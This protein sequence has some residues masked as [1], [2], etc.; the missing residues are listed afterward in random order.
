[1]YDQIHRLDRPVNILVQKTTKCHALQ[2][3]I[4]FGIDLYNGRDT[5][6]VV[7]F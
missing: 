4:A 1:M 2:Y 3:V 7:V 6:Y 5:M